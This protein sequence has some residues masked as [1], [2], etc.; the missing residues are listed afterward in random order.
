MVVSLW[1]LRLVGQT[2]ACKSV[3]F[4]LL[5]LMFE[6]GNPRCCDLLPAGYKNAFGTQ[7]VAPL[8]VMFMPLQKRI[9]VVVAAACAF[10]ISCCASRVALVIVF[11][12]SG[13]IHVS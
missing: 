2:T 13:S 4:N 5:R 1:E 11:T 12:F 9:H 6:Q 7:T 8:A 10:W 3:V